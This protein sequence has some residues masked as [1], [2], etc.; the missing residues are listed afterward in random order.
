MPRR[1]RLSI[2]KT[3]IKA[4]FTSLTYGTTS[5]SINEE[6]YVSIS[7]ASE[8]GQSKRAC[9]HHLW[10]HGEKA[11]KTSQKIIF[12]TASR[13]SSWLSSWPSKTRNA[14]AN[15][16]RTEVKTTD[17]HHQISPST[18]FSWY[19]GILTTIKATMYVQAWQTKADKLM[20]PGLDSKIKDLK[21]R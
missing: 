19:I 17:H 8:H 5:T 14:R 4:T 12:A 13:E 6:N 7:E 9:W 11:R 10:T 18:G 20:L 2:T 16:I 21:A 3:F 15:S 1:G